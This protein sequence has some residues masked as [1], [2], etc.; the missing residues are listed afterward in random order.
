MLF[1]T[2]VAAVT[3]ADTTVEGY[4]NTVD[5]VRSGWDVGYA[6]VFDTDGTLV[7]AI[8]VMVGTD[9]QVV[10]TGAEVAP[11]AEVTTGGGHKRSR[12]HNPR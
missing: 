12:G 1:T 10:T 4:E 3:G 8:C 9:A 6:N 5:A 2:G 7:G 11:G